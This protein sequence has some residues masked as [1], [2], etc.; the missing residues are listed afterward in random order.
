[1][2][3]ALITKESQGESQEE[4]F[5]SK[6]VTRRL[7]PL[8]L[9]NAICSKELLYPGLLFMNINIGCKKLLT[10]VD[11]GATN[12]FVV[13]R[14]VRNLGLVNLVTQ[15]VHGMAL[16]VQSFVSFWN[17]KANFISIALND[18]DIILGI[19]F[20]VEFK[21]VVMPHLNRLFVMDK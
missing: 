13:E 2:I 6:K 1:M 20:L 16:G 8:Q 10:L 18:F 15:V 7:N 5:G 21:G 19:E 12:K 4:D 14:L 11:S 9:L 17:G 3:S